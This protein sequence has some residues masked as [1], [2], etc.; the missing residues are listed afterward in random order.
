MC[1]QEDEGCMYLY[2]INL[3]DFVARMFSMFYTS[4]SKKAAVDKLTSITG[5]VHLAFLKEFY[6]FNIHSLIRGVLL[7]SCSTGAKNFKNYVFC[8]P[9]FSCVIQ[10]IESHCAIKAKKKFRHPLFLFSVENS[11]SYISFWCSELLMIYLC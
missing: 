1:T 7:Q 4:M 5:R 8:H 9:Q 10:N 6:M 2:I 3:S 11:Y